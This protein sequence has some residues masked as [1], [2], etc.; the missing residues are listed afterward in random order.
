ME[1]LFLS[2]VLRATLLYT[3]NNSNAAEAPSCPSCLVKTAFT[4]RRTLDR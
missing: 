4:S 1:Y 3:W 2:T